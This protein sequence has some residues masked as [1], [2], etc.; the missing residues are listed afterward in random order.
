MK[1][2]TVSDA[3]RRTLMLYVRVTSAEKERLAALANEAG[4]TVSDWIRSKA[5]DVRPSAPRLLPG[6]ETLLSVLYHIS[7]TGVNLNQV[8]RQLNRKQDS[9]DFEVPIEQISVLIMELKGIAATV[10]K[11]LHEHH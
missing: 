6:E 3:N 5:I 9:M 1:N 7:K 8:A 10:R 11:A 2:T 4:L